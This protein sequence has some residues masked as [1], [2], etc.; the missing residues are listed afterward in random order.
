[1]SVTVTPGP[2]LQEVLHVVP[3][4]HGD[5]RGWFSETYNAAAFAQ[6][7]QLFVPEGFAHGFSTL[8]QGCEIA[9]KVSAPYAPE[10]DG[11][12]HLMIRIPGS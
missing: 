12:L 3:T 1:M 2:V 4:P 10:S 8:E 6:V 11:A 9:S 5:A 7:N